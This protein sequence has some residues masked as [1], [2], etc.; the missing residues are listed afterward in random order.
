MRA[1]IFDMIQA[2]AASSGGLPGTARWLDCY[3]GTGSVGLEALSRGVK[4]SDQ[5]RASGSAPPEIP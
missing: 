4:A 5:A 1:A 3:A 2:Q